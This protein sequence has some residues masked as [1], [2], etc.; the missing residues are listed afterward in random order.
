MKSECYRHIKLYE[1]YLNIFKELPILTLKAKEGVEINNKTI[2][3]LVFKPTSFL[4][5]RKLCTI[6]AS[7]YV[8][9]KRKIG[10]GRMANRRNEYMMFISR[11]EVINESSIKWLKW[12][13]LLW[14]TALFAFREQKNITVTD[15]IE[16]DLIE[17]FSGIVIL[18]PELLTDSK[19]A[20]CY[21]SKNNFVSIFQI[22][23]VKREL[24]N[25]KLNRGQEGTYWLIEQFY[26]H[27]DDY[28]IIASNALVEF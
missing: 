5:F 20:K 13:A 11:N 18:L 4:P 6:G 25:E 2:T 24:M 8:M 23:P 28:K 7:D 15:T 17:N 10:L 16:T 14:N 27:D 19:S 26:T 22:M 1:H 3:T 12:N 21:L 9:P